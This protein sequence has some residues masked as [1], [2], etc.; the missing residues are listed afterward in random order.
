[1]YQ[2][3]VPGEPFSCPQHGPPSLL[4]FFHFKKIL[5]KSV[6]TAPWTSK[7]LKLRR[8]KGHVEDKPREQ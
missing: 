7:T 8:R 1:M 6:V 4:P 5:I 3:G 2:H